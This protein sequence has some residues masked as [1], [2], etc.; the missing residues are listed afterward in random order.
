MPMQF[1][2]SGFKSFKMEDSDEN[3]ACGSAKSD[4]REPEPLSS[5]SCS[6]DIWRKCKEIMAAYAH[7]IDDFAK[8]PVVDQQKL[9]DASWVEVVSLYT[10]CQL[11]IP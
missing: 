3:V 9:I 8:L 6:S 2:D 7:K 5:G 10:A 1:E 11:A 4:V